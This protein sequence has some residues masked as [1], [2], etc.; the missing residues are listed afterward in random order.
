MVDNTLNGVI[1]LSEQ[2]KHSDTEPYH[3]DFPLFVI[4]QLGQNA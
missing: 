1:D 4:L 3:D 2:I